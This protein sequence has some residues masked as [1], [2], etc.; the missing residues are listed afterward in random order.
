MCIICNLGDEYDAGYRFLNA[1]SQSGASMQKAADA[2]LAV[3]KAAP[4]A[5]DRR[6]YDHMH[7]LMVRQIRDWNRLEAIR[8]KPLEKLSYEE[9]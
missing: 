5:E 1:F 7:K 4:Q 2:M 9:R 6:R 8:E 3:S